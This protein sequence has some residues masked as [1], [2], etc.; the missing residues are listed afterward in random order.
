MFSMYS[1]LWCSVLVVFD[2]WYLY[3]GGLG[4]IILLSYVGHY[5]GTNDTSTSIFNLNFKIHSYI[6]KTFVAT[7]KIFLGKL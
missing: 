4:S 7:S 3:L 5:F 1:V 2:T 6:F